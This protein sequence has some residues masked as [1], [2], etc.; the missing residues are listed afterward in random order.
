MCLSRAFAKLLLAQGERCLLRRGL[1]GGKEGAGPQSREEGAC[2]AELKHS[3]HIRAVPCQELGKPVHP[4]PQEGSSCSS[5][6]HWVGKTRLVSPSEPVGRA[7]NGTHRSRERC[8]G[9]GHHSPREAPFRGRDAQLQTVG[10]S[11]CP[12]CAVDVT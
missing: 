2:P 9:P 12:T 5:L 11:S 1:R 6:N 8:H 3:P 7:S 10:P 4:K